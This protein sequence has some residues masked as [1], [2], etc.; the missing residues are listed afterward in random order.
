MTSGRVAAMVLA[1]VVC[2]A[3]AFEFWR[4]A[5]STAAIDFYQMWVGARM[6][7][8][9]RDFY[10]PAEGAR[11]GESFRREAVAAGSS[12]RHIA[13]ATYRRNLEIYASPLLYMMYAP[14]PDT[15]ERALTTFQVIAFI[16]LLAAVMMFGALF[17]W[18]AERRVLF[19]GALLIAYGPVHSD[20]TVGNANAIML[21]IMGVMSFAI[22]R[23]RFAFAGALLAISVVAKPNVAMLFPLVYIFWTAQRRW[24]NVAAHAAGAGVATIIAMLI[25]AIYYRS[26]TIWGEWIGSL[27]LMPR[28]TVVPLE[29]GNF[30]VARMLQSLT[31]AS[32]TPVLFIV[33]CAAAA[34][35]A[36]RSRSGVSADIPLIAIGLCLF[37]LVSPLVWVHYFML[38]IP[39][40][41][42]LL[43][44]AAPGAHAARRQIAAL[45]ALLFM[46]VRPWDSFA[47][48]TLQVA[49]IANAGLFIALIAATRE[50]LL[51]GKNR[52]Q[53]EEDGNRAEDDDGEDDRHGH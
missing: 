9:T 41:M 38:A 53:A 40:V 10:D 27:I 46:A 45:A 28:D 17:R 32:A 12:R 33:V 19:F 5:R 52:V 24:R 47:S 51:L 1:G 15:Y 44:P 14:L 31:S 22:L 48:T 7:R 34:F 4:T 23:A 50:L 25:C 21:A 2:A 6:G 13:V 29:L 39:V 49:L 16:S 37:H 18:P 8:E 3:G 35:L 11:F 26:L 42:W 43:R 20:L 36:V 30:S